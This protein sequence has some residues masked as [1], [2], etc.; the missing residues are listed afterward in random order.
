MGRW[1]VGSVTTWPNQITPLDNMGL[2]LQ[3][4][5]VQLPVYGLSVRRAEELGVGHHPRLVRLLGPPLQADRA[6]NDQPA[7]PLAVA[8]EGAQGG[9]WRFQ[10]AAPRRPRPPRRSSRSQ[11]PSQT[12]TWRC[13]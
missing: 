12:G 10:V 9:Q 6:V 7:A 11:G 3:F 2:W 4:F 13:S 5:G 1:S 8:D